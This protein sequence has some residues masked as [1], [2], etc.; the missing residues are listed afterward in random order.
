MTTDEFE[1]MDQWAKDF[2]DFHAHFAHLFARSEPREE[3]R[4]YVRGLVAPVAR[5]NCWQMAEVVGE[6]DPQGMQRLLY[7]AHC[8]PNEARD[9]LPRFVVD[10]FGHDSGIVVVDETGFLKKGTKSV[11]VKRQYS[12]T[13]GKIENCQV[14]VSLSYVNRRST[15]FWTGDFTCRRI[16]AQTGN[17]V[18]RRGCRMKR[19]SR[20]SLSWRGRC[21][22]TPGLRECRGRG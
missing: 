9:E 8:E 2:E 7:S 3:A 5:K 14:G 21:W 13:A 16:G 22:S 19:R 6:D 1:Q 10:Q 18:R 20:R 15:P 12:D 4:Q 17:G 11:G